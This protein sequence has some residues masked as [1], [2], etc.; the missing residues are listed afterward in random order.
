MLFSV[1]EDEKCTDSLNLWFVITG[2]S[3][4]VLILLVLIILVIVCMC[5]R[6]TNGTHKQKIPI[7]PTH[8]EKAEEANNSIDA[9]ATYKRRN[10]NEDMYV[11]TPDHP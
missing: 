9:Y 10:T 4:L 5:K 6:F 1:Y 2:I 8:E 7:T 11:Q 3:L